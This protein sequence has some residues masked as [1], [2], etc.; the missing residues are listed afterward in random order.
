M[1]EVNKKTVSRYRIMRTDPPVGMFMSGQVMDGIEKRDDAEEG[2][3]ALSNTRGSKFI[4]EEYETALHVQFTSMCCKCH[5]REVSMRY[6]EAVYPYKKQL[7]DTVIT[8]AI[9]GREERI[10]CDCRNCSYSWTSKTVDNSE[11]LT[12]ITDGR[13]PVIKGPDSL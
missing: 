12:M 9:P 3:R 7:L 4:V 1:D 2:A 5:S 11:Q 10:K 6:H 13:T 8:V